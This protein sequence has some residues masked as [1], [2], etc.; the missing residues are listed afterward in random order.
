VLHALP[1][2]FIIHYLYSWSSSSNLGWIISRFS[3]VTPWKCRNNAYSHVITT[4]FLKYISCKSSLLVAKT[5]FKPRIG[6]H[7]FEIL[8]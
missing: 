2:Q 3:W 6:T 7:Y 4:S 1:I 5:R 8:F